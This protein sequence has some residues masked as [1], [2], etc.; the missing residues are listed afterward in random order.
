LAAVS[1][2][3]IRTTMADSFAEEPP[4]ADIAGI[5]HSGVDPGETDGG[6]EDVDREPEPGKLPANDT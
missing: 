3:E 6:G 1:L 5:V 2:A 4:G